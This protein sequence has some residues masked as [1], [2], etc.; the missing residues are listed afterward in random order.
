MSEIETIIARAVWEQRRNHAEKH[1]I[2]LEEWGDGTHARINGV[3]EETQ[4]AFAALA[5]AGFHIC[6]L[7]GGVHDGACPTCGCEPVK[8]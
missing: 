1:D 2:R 8:S 5:A 6:R 3:F 4:A 7:D